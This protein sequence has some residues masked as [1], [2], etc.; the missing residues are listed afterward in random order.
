MKNYI[1]ILLVIFAALI[2]PPEYVFSQSEETIKIESIS[3]VLIEVN[4]KD[5]TV[6]I[7]SNSRVVKFYATSEICT[8]FKNSINSEIN[9]YFTRRSSEGLQLVKMNLITK[10]DIDS[11]KNENTDNKKKTE[12]Y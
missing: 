1:K 10:T 9:I 4:E 2:M 12:N 8:E 6:F 11:S 5:L 3:G 7:R